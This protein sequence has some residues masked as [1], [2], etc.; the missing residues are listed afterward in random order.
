MV[1]YEEDQDRYIADD[2]YVIRRRVFGEH[3]EWQIRY[4]SSLSWTSADTILE[5]AEAIRQAQ[6]QH[7]QRL[8]AE[9]G[10]APQDGPALEK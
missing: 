9:A 7:A 2:K 1:R 3:E 8:A 5:M 6:Q 10:G 4:I